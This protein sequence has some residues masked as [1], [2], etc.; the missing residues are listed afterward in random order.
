MAKCE[1][2]GKTTTFGG[3]VSHRSSYLTGRNKRKVYPNLKKT[4]VPVDGVMKKM[5]VC[6]RCLRTS[7]KTNLQRQ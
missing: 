7:R 2:C 3:T 1:L 4:G 5:T 6:T